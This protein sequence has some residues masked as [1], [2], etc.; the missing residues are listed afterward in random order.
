MR[1]RSLLL[2][3]LAL[4]AAALAAPLAEAKTKRVFWQQRAA[5]AARF[6]EQ[7]GF[8]P[9]N[10]IQAMKD[11]RPVPTRVKA[12]RT[13]YLVDWANALYGRASV[14]AA[15]KELHRGGRRD[16][17]IFTD[18]L[19]TRAE[20]K[21]YEVLLDLAR[22][23]DVL[24]VHRDNPACAAGL[25]RAQARGI[26]RGEITRWSQVVPLG[27]GQ[28]DAI[29]RHLIGSPDGGKGTAFPEPRLGVKTKDLRKSSGIVQADGGVSKVA[30]GDRSVAA[31]TSWSRVR[32][33]SGVCAVP[34]D[35]VAPSNESVHALKYPEAYPVQFVM[36]RKR[37]R[38]KESRVR[39]KAYVKFLRSARAA[40]LF[41]SS[42]VLL[43]AD[44]PGGVNPVNPGGSGGSGGG[45]VPGP[46]VDYAG[47]PITTQQDDA[48]ALAA[49]TGTRFD[50]QAVQR[51]AFNADRA[52]VTLQ[53]SE[54]GSSCTRTQGAW[55]VLI[56]WRY[57][58]NGGGVIAMVR[59]T[60]A[61]QREVQIDLPNEVPG[62]AFM[63]GQS[64]ARDP[65]LSDSCF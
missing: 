12:G 21:R 54:D 26:A 24:V 47:R 22:D 57:A 15:L 43:A 51:F 23:A 9:I 7:I 32:F 35:G 63:D 33:N 36:H 1:H 60:T 42:G 27:G 59:L 50:Q 5:V 38:L 40:E 20:K 46:P 45:N 62:Q 16:D 48:A 13:T 44:P 53:Y 58:E 28:P 14:G 29:E 11:G 37:S 64:F 55:E 19:L 61:D 65:G 17:G 18:R 25:T 4:A 34:L 31:V 41:R 3:V 2:I 56:G 30:S 39:V 6:F 10:G 49:L 52:L 8:I